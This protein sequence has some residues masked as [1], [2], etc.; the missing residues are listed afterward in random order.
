MPDRS[1]IDHSSF[2]PLLLGTVYDEI[3]LRVRIGRKFG[4]LLNNGDGDRRYMDIQ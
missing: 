4:N 3:E 2:K 1:S